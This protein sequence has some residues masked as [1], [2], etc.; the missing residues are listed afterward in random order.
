MRGGNDSIELFLSMI[1]IVSESKSVNKYYYVCSFRYQKRKEKK[2][3]LYLEVQ[4]SAH[5]IKKKPS[6]EL[7]WYFYGLW[8]FSEYLKQDTFPIRLEIT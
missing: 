4:L 3:K 5:C 1:C 7:E 8:H 6:G 2:E